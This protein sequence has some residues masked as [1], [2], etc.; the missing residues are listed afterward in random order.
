[1]NILVNYTPG[2]AGPKIMKG[3]VNAFRR[4][5]HFVTDRPQGDELQKSYDVILGYSGTSV[6]IVDEKNGLTLDAVLKA[7]LIQYWADDVEDINKICRR[8][9]IFQSD[10]G[11]S[12]KWNALGVSNI[13]LP[14]A[15]DEKVFYPIE[16]GKRFDVILTGVP[17]APRIEI[18]KQLE[19]LN[20][21][22]FGQ[23]ERGWEKYSEVKKYYYGCVASENELNELYNQS[24]ICIDIS[25]PQ[26]LNSANFTVFNAMASGC[27][28][29][30]NYKTA[31]DGL[32]GAEQVPSYTGSCRSLIDKYL[33]DEVLLKGESLR[34]RDVILSGHTF[35]H[36]V[37]DML[38][39]LRSVTG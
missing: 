13:Y 7:C 12:E 20:V 5:G 33:A 32:F 26:N 37:E 22:V 16:M 6:I 24:K 23:W 2:H 11:C 19:G 30:T 15:A 27:L 29:I 35:I 3:F 18:L 28:L 9:I 39:I 38:S 31:L 34:Q 4:L 10:L 14:L 8:G 21:A 25:S 1:M 17:S 36:R